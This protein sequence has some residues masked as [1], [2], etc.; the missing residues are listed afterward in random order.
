MKVLLV[1]PVEI[2]EETDS[3]IT[4]ASVLTLSLEYLQLKAGTISTQRMANISSR[5]EN[6][7]MA[8]TF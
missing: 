4:Q 7:L 6:H 2:Q 1:V 3:S 8:E 5:K